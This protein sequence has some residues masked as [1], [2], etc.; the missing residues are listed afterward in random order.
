MEAE[1]ERSGWLL[2]SSWIALA[3][4]VGGYFA[5]PPVVTFLYHLLGHP[6]HLHAG[7]RNTLA[8]GLFG[9]SM[10]AS[11]GWNIF[12]F[13]ATC[14]ALRRSPLRFPVAD[15]RFVRRSAFGLATGLA[16]ML[17]CI[18]AIW[19]TNSA[20]IVFSGQTAAATV[21]NGL[22]W[23]I[24]E[25]IGAAGEELFARGTLLLVAKRF[26]G[27]RGAVLVS[28]LIF[29]VEHLGNPGASW[30]WLLRLFFQGML[31]SYAVFRTGSLWWS[32]SYHAGWNWVSAPLFGAL[33]SG[34]LD[35]GHIFN[36]M[37]TGSRWLTGGSVGPEGSIF[38]FVAVL[39]AFAVLLASMRG[40]KQIS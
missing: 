36:F 20:T 12:L 25:Y 29:A 13:S 17:G 31:L 32:V 16:V 8:E 14:F 28:G 4:V 11:L 37:P 35:E 6:L 22:F 34:Y 24:L 38:A 9:V 30:I 26:L 39:C 19:A 23:L 3:V 7:P 18:I 27:W 33:G 1:V 10:V 2:P 40:T 5:T 15:D 21:R